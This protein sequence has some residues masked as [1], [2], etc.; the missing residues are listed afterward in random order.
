MPALIEAMERQGH[1][2]LAPEIR[3]KLL[4]MRAATI[5]RALARVREALGRKRWRHTTH[6]LRRSIPIRTSA[7]WN[8]PAPGC[9]EADLVA[10]NGPSACGSFI[11]TLVLTDIAIGWTECVPL[12]LR[13]QTLLS[14]VLSELRKQLPFALAGLDT[15]NDTVFMNQTLKAYCG[16]ASIV[17]TRCGPYRKNDQAFVEQKNGAVVRRMVGYRRFEGLEAAKLLA[18]HYRSA[19][20]FVNFFQP[21]FKLMTK[22]RDGARVRKTYSAPA[23]PHQRLVADAR[24]PDAVRH[25]LEEIFAALDPVGCCATFA[26]RR[27]ASRARGYPVNCPSCWPTDR[28]IVKAKRGRAVL[29]RSSGRR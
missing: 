22:Q 28:P 10:H 2:G 5:D 19:R 9:V 11:Q 24:T 23:T 12:I 26:A 14:T 25:H 1:L 20:L 3:D 7:D 6:S 16:A 15:D 17:F 4:A 18:K 8:D 29:T 27:N 21:P 13:E